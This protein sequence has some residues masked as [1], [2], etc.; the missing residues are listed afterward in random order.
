MWIRKKSLQKLIDDEVKRLVKLEMI[1]HKY[2]VSAELRGYINDHLDDDHIIKEYWSKLPSKDMCYN[3]DLSDI[4]YK[5]LEYLNLE[6]K[7]KQQTTNIIKKKK[8]Q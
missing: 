5:L 6:I 7:T 1:E 4:I 3:H 8:D 2:E